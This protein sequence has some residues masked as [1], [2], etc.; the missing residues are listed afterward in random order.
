MSVLI[1]DADI[2]ESDDHIQ[3]LQERYHEIIK[4]YNKE[5]AKI[6][7]DKIKD[8]EGDLH[9]LW[10]TEELDDAPSHYHV[11]AC[12]RNTGTLMDIATC[13]TTYHSFLQELYLGNDVKLIRIVCRTEKGK[14]VEVKQ[15]NF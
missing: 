9:M 10:Q 4:E 2:P 11:Q 15:N 1:F 3:A 6:P 12:I 14:W 7:T 13:M 8:Q 5:R